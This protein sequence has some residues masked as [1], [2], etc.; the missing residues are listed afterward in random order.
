MKTCNVHIPGNVQC[1]YPALW[2]LT[3]PVNEP[4]A[5]ENAPPVFREVSRTVCSHH[6]EYAIL[7]DIGRVPSSASVSVSIAIGRP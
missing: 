1:P 2:Q 5:Y 4:A 3:W 7:T 6:L